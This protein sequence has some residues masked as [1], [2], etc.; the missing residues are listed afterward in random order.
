[1][2]KEE[3]H[4][5]LKIVNKVLLREAAMTII[6]CLLLTLAFFAYYVMGLI[7]VMALNAIVD[8]KWFLLKS[9]LI[10]IFWPLS[11][12]ILSVEAIIR[13]TIYFFVLIKEGKRI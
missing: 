13:M 4:V 2:T 9:A 12:M 5:L 7:T 8:E 6:A 3:R 10:I 11:P 1:L